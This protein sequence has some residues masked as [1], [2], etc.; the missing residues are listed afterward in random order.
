MFS[1]LC[2]NIYCIWEYII[3]NEEYLAAQKCGM[4]KN[5]DKGNNTFHYAS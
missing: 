3:Q 1:S 4:K 2:A 5:W